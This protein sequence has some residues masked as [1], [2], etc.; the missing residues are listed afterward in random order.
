MEILAMLIFSRLQ[1]TNEE[2][3]LSAAKGQSMRRRKHRT[4]RAILQFGLTL[5]IGR[6]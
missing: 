5:S 4:D 6:G 2:S 3:A 1:S